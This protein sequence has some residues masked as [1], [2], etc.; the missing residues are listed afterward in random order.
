MGVGGARIITSK[1]YEMVVP[2]FET[3][4]AIADAILRRRSRR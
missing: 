2:R 4:L 1:V 3:A